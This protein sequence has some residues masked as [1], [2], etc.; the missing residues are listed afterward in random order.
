MSFRKKLNE[1]KGIEMV[2]KGDDLLKK[3]DHTDII[4]TPALGRPF[5]LGML[6]DRV[7]D[8]IIPG[9]TLL[10]MQ[11]MENHTF[12]ENRNGSSFEVIYGD[13]FE[14]KSVVFNGDANLEL[15]VL[16]GKVTLGSSG[17][18]LKNKISS[19]KQLRI[20]LTAE[21][22]MLYKELE[23]KHFQSEISNT[24]ANATHIVTAIEYGTNVAF[25]FERSISNSEDMQEVKGELT[26]MIDCI[27]S[28]HASGKAE[29]SMKNI[30]KQKA[31]NISCKFYG[32]IILPVNPTTYEEAVRVYKELP[33]YLKEDKAVPVT[34]WLYPIH[35]RITPENKVLQIINKE[36]MKEAVIA[37]DDLQ[38]I[39]VSCND[40]MTGQ[41]YVHIPEIK[42]KIDKFR[43]SVQH[44]QQDFYDQVL[45]YLLNEDNQ[46]TD[47]MPPR[48]DTIDNM[49]HWISEN[50][51]T[52]ISLLNTFINKIKKEKIEILSKVGVDA[53]LFE[54]D[55]LIILDIDL[56]FSSGQYVQKEPAK[57]SH[58]TTQQQE[59]SDKQTLPSMQESRRHEP[60]TSSASAEVNSWY[61][62]SNIKAYV[63]KTIKRFL[64]LNTTK[65]SHFKFFVTFTDRI[66]PHDKVSSCAS[67]VLYEDGKETKQID[68]FSSELEK[69][70]CTVL[71]DVYH[72][73]TNA[74]MKVVAKKSY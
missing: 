38:R 67:V 50:A 21:Y 66:V 39:F 45:N 40:I 58:S 74:G 18:F 72:V 57:S 49:T 41:A 43:R 17:K 73:F 62:D 27:P 33:S 44:F 68:F 3:S 26:G 51:E 42:F 34:V 48:H 63:R 16:T 46:S 55:H 24:K 11:D 32:D 37:L 64:T 14:D 53:K 1:W 59:S 5:R 4:R 65:A 30:D 36:K 71:R 19:K 31:E 52:E 60:K 2:D 9:E 70:L 61:T 15:N 25:A 10:T 28:F 22:I 29:I 47:K 13:T 20:T 8:T 6:Y 69:I 56:P 35:K 23:M 12:K 7:H 54:H